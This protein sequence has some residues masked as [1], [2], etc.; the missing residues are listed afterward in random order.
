M[1]SR[2]Q[3]LEELFNTELRLVKKF[4]PNI[5]VENFRQRW[6]KVTPA[7]EIDRAWEILLDLECQE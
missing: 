2:E 5:D 4:N 3:A 7:H 6:D 1:I